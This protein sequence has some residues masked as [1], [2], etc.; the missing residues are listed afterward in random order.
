MLKPGGRFYFIEH[1]ADGPDGPDGPEGGARTRT[2]RRRLQ[3]ALT[4]SGLWPCLGDG[5]RLNR[6]TEM[7]IRNAGFEK[8]F[9]R[10]LSPK[11]G[12]EIFDFHRWRW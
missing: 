9:S 4:N 1:V 11:L 10:R 3:D 6:E 12:E 2:A 5:C 7:H 8:V